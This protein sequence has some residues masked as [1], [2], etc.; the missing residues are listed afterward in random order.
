MCL[1]ECV[2]GLFWF[3]LWWC[4]SVPQHAVP[5]LYVQFI[6][7]MYKHNASLHWRCL[8]QF[9]Y[10]SGTNCAEGL[11]TTCQVK[12]L[13][14]LLFTLSEVICC[15]GRLWFGGLVLGLYTAL[16]PR[17]ITA[18]FWLVAYLLFQP[19]DGNAWIHS[20]FLSSQWKTFKRF[21]SYWEGNQAALRKQLFLSFYV[22]VCTSWVILTSRLEYFDR[23]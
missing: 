15:Q 13:S 16:L 7:T 14:C 5:Q 4:S 3:A 23:D 17:A 12:L 21:T 10:M 2:I 11:I 1:C 6:P 19:I 8:S 20:S 18:T 9:H 22:P